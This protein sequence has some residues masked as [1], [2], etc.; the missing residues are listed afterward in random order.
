[1]QGPE[2]VQLLRRSYDLFL[3]LQQQTGQ[4]GF[5]RGGEVLGSSDGPTAAEE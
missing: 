2:Y 5:S 3:D 1:M 4:V